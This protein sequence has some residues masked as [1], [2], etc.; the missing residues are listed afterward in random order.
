MLLRNIHRTDTRKS[1]S[2][3]QW[4]VTYYLYIRVLL[5]AGGILQLG[6]SLTNLAHRRQMPD[7]AVSFVIFAVM[8][9]DAAVVMGLFHPRSSCM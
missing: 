5:A 7:A 6:L 1:C 4:Q 2:E 8:D 9:R 3:N